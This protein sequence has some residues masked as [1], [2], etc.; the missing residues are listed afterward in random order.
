MPQTPLTGQHDISRL[1]NMTG[2]AFAS[3]SESVECSNLF[4]DRM[5][6]RSEMARQARL[7]D[8]S[9]EEESY[10]ASMD[11]RHPIQRLVL[12][13]IGHISFVQDAMRSEVQGTRLMLAIELFADR[14]GRYPQSLDE[15]VPDVL[16]SIP[17]DAMSAAGF[18]YTT[19]LGN[20]PYLVYVRDD[21]QDDTTQSGNQSYLLYTVGGDGQ[22][23]KGKQAPQPR[24]AFELNRGG[25]FDFVFNQDRPVAG[26]LQSDSTRP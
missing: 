16:N 18:M 12:P 14:K 13:S 11:W 23:D 17:I 9:F 20:Q 2:L 24:D 22:D 26:S 19:Q 10:V 25:G 21:G 7:A 3:R 8:N 1:W 5:I 4:F 6:H 15:L